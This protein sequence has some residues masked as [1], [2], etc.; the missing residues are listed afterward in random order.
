M[1]GVVAASAILAGTDPGR[2]QEPTDEQVEA[3]ARVPMPVISGIADRVALAGAVGRRGIVQLPTR[4]VAEWTPA[5]VTAALR[6][7]DDGMLERPADLVEAIMGDDRVQGVL[8]TRTHGLLGLPVQFYGGDAEGEQVRRLEGTKALQGV[9]AIPGDWARMFPESEL[10]Q[11]MAWGLLLGVGL[12]ERVPDESRG[13][14]EGSAPVI[15]VWHPRWLRHDWMTGRWLLTTA[16]GEVEVVPGD[17]RWILF[18]PYGGL[19]PWTQGAWRP[20][21]FA[22]VLKQFALH[23][24]ARHSEVLGSAARVGTVP[25]G[26][27]EDIRRKWLRDLKNLGRDNAMVIEQGYKLELVEATGRTWEIYTAQIE[28][29]DRAIAITLAGQFVTTEGTKGFS[30]GTIHAEIRHDLIRFTAES[31]ATCLHEQGLRPWAVENYGGGAANDNN[32][33][34][35][36]APWARWDTQPPADKL[37][38]AQALQALGSAISALDAALAPSGVRVDARELAGEYAVALVELPATGAKAPTIALAPT[39][40]VKIVKVDEARAAAGVGPWTN[41]D[42]SRSPDGQLTVAQFAAKAEAAAVAPPPVPA[43]LAPPPAPPLAE[44]A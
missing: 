10:A 11:L 29:A 25:T 30:N 2:A 4:T 18:T 32:A 14:G 15:V 13:I 38:R 7:A 3:W 17:G 33:A 20:I 23:D 31:L 5:Q 35:D 22:W 19:R 16:E 41:P 36:T 9:P 28:W 39:D 37:A 42:G 8:S 26:A 6:Q 1:G 34:A 40:V 21:A 27:D 24:R 12:A 44:A 43:A